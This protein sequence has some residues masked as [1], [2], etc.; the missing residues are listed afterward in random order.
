MIGHSGKLVIEALI[1]VIAGIA[2]LLGV[3]FWR[4]SEGPISVE[5]L[6]DQLEAAFNSDDSELEVV[7]GETLIAWGGWDRSLELWT[8]DWRVL[9]P[10]GAVVAVLPEMHVRVSISALFNG[11]LA[12]TEIDLVGIEL[13][14]F[15]REDGS[16]G[17]T[18]KIDPDEDRAGQDFGLV[19]PVVLQQLLSERD[20]EEPLSYLRRVTITDAVLNLRDEPLGLSWTTPASTIVLERAEP[21]L[22]ASA[23][24]DLQYEEGPSAKIDGALL[25]DRAIGSLELV[26]SFDNLNPQQLAGLAP[27]LAPLE[28][29]NLRADGSVS[30]AMFPDGRIETVSIA[31][32]SPGGTAALPEVYAQ[33]FVLQ[34]LALAATYT[35]ADRLLAVENLSY[36]LDLGAQPGPS[37][38]VSANLQWSE[39]GL[40]VAIEAKA[41][42]IGSDDIPLLWPVDSPGNG[43][44]WVSENVTAG[45]ATDAAV[46]VSLSLPDMDPEKL[47]VKRLDGSYRFDDLEVHFLRP[48][49]PITGINGTAVFDA[50]SMTF[51][52]EQGGIGEI[53]SPGSTVTLYDFDTEVSKA[54]IDFAP[55]GPLSAA[56]EL[57][58]H[59]RLRLI[60]GLGLDPASISG[61]AAAQVKMGYP[62]ID[63]LT[64]DGVQVE[65]KGELSEVAIRELLL[66]QG[67]TDGDLDLDLQK[68]GMT[69]QGGAVFGG[70]P[71]NIHWEEFFEGGREFTTQLDVDAPRVEAAQ[72][73]DFGLETGDYLAGPFA[74]G[75]EVRERSDGSGEAGVSA[76]LAS[77]TLALPLLEWEK[78]AGEP[79]SVAAVL[80]FDNSGL[81][82]ING[83]DFN[84]GDFIARGAFS[85]DPE[86]QD[87]ISASFSELRLQQS[88]LVN[89]T[90][91]RY[92]EGV[93]VNIGGGEL[94]LSGLLSE[95]EEGDSPPEEA[96]PEQAAE[97]SYTPLRVAGERLQKVVLGE[98]R[99]L[100]NVGFELQRGTQGWEVIEIDGSVPRPL[101]RA[102]G[103]SVAED[104]GIAEK[105]FEI[106]F[107]PGVDATRPSEYGLLVR[108][109]DAGAVLRAMDWVDTLEG[110]QLEVRGHSPGPLPKGPL[111]ASVEAVNYRLVEAPLLARLLSAALLTGIGDLLSGD[112]IGFNRFTGDFTLE[113]GVMRT[114]LLR[115]YGPGLGITIKGTAN[116]ET[117]RLDLGGTLV[118]A[119]A[120]NQILGSIPILG[121]ILTG[122]EGGGVIG[123]V[124]AIEGPLD[125]PDVSVNPLSALTP[126]FLRGLFEVQSE[127]D[128]EENQF[129]PQAYPDGTG[130]SV[131]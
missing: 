120:V 51:S 27:Q 104:S 12:P 54:Q 107:G 41:A 109:D 15:R 92:G 55:R 101:W 66:G 18:P 125:D 8:R 89:T 29:V 65:A 56:L 46:H 53:R 34:D 13:D 71:V 87:V 23:S 131:R 85:V 81:L 124:Y 1:G 6:D 37:M 98:G 84:A 86:S 35:G 36:R 62:L 64:F 2:I 69:L 116:F 58:N 72:L 121:D 128:G 114:D 73:A 102:D 112:G 47:L 17:M 94:D 110:G 129:V 96:A 75:F 108:A 78:P 3:A 88:F 99:Y 19:A 63:E 52:V 105:R 70:I 38:A 16:F 103:Q 45:G 42:D 33:P 31:L 11:V 9:A 60:E 40:G 48:M 14:L 59:P 57:L 22:R 113:D 80:L 24:F 118:P 91:R 10:D 76:N 100:E 90:L 68:D 5:F 44:S 119:Y 61:S 74:A 79:A 82:A 130:T 43:R 20:P 111:Q 95:D 32:T 67:V 21:G 49:P 122:G 117:D 127:D 83:V 4:L 106:D 26:L 28:G 39:A 126:G 25:Y 123:V 93:E 115:A 7:V 77:A 97:E 30:G 50:D